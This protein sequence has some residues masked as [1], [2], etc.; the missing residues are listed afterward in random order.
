MGAGR[1]LV[2]DDESGVQKVLSY[3]LR[4]EGFEVVATDDGENAIAEY[5]KKPFDLVIHDLKMPK[6]DGIELLRRLK[7]RDPEATVVV[8]T[9]Y[10]TW[11]TAVEAM[12][13]GAHD[14]IN[15]PF[16][17]DVIRRTA[18]TLVERKRLWKQLP[19]EIRE[20]PFHM[21]DIIGGSPQMREVFDVISRIAPTNTTVLITGESGTGKEIV[22]RALHYGSLRAFGP[23]MPVNCGAFTESLLE[24]ELFGHL[25]G[26]FTGAVCDKKGMIEVADGG[27]LFLDEVGEMSHATQVSLLRALETR[28]IRPVGGVEQ[29]FI[30]VR[31]IAATNSDLAGQMRSGR[32]REDLYYRLNVITVALP[33]LRERKEDVPLL[34]GR[35]LALASKKTGKT[36][37]K[38]S[39]DA[40][41][42]L[43]SYDWPGNVRELENA[44]ER[45]VVLA[46]GET[47]TRAEVTTGT[48]RPAPVPPTPEVVLGPGK[49]ID[50]DRTLE[51]TERAYILRALELT[52]WNLTRAA[53]VLETSFRS[54]RYRVKKLGIRR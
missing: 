37:R 8:I 5:G 49:T 31:F 48:P 27:T 38:I 52:D 20:R 25:R 14:Y 18:R 28:Q 35:F 50:L 22:A 53:K 40:M 54:L 4:Q 2:V 33:P 34:A 7:E 43:V 10:G 44:I 11:D 45:A 15:K 51:E 6:L 36:V 47:V 41:E 19:E 17:T 1:V 9:A 16:D 32:F 46:E 24:S 42:L 26:A 29:R 39:D 30:D 13:L 21:G 23:F 12:R 3:V